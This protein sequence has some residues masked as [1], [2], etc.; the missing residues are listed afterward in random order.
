MPCS[1]KRARVLLERGRARVHRLMPFVIRLTD[2]LVE[3]SSLQPVRVKIE[4]GS[5]ATGMS[6][7]READG[8]TAVLNL[9]ELVHRGSQIR[10][11]LTGRSNFRRRRRSANLRYRAARFSNRAVKRGSLPPSLQ[12]RV[13]TMQSWTHRFIRWA[14]VTGIA[15]EVVRYSTTTI[16]SLGV[17]TPAPQEADLLAHETRAYLLERL[18]YRCAYCG[19]EGREL[20]VDPIT[21]KASLTTARITDLTLA[22]ASC[23]KRKGKKDISEFV[24]DSRHLARLLAWRKAPQRDAGAIN[25]ARAAIASWLE[26]SGL[27]VE[28]ASGGRTKWNRSRLG[29]PKSPALNAVCVGVVNTVSGWDCPILE[30]KTAGRGRYQRTLPDKSGFPRGY[31]M[32]K[33]RVHN[34][35]TG[36]RVRANVPAG[37]NI[38]AHTGRVSVRARGNFDIQTPRGVVHGVSHKHCAVLQRADGYSYSMRACGTTTVP[39]P[40][41]H[42]LREQ[43][44]E[45]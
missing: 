15:S 42:L 4:P 5:K 31:L 3:E 27:S 9:F 20:R 41:S 32:R 22:C 38:G 8:H 25:G 29:L 13:V 17:A 26:S 34:F 39:S 28:L 19:A 14:P 12:H 36:D 35:Q 1:E 33:K 11:A 21:P 23:I 10:E 30:I 40:I 37:K 6:L 45:G 18:E 44:I 24:T 16:A 7:V 2:R 43:H